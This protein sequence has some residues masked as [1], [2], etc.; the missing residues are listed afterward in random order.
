MNSDPALSEKS[1]VQRAAAIAARLMAIKL[2]SMLDDTGRFTYAYNLDPDVTVASDYNWLRHFGAIYSLTQA[3]E[4][5][6]EGPRYER[7]APA[8]SFAKI[9]TFGQVEGLGEKR[10]GVW[11]RPEF[12]TYLENST[13]KTGG[14]GLA[15]LVFARAAKLG[16]AAVELTDLNRLQAYLLE[17][18][19]EDGSFH[20]FFVEGEGFLAGKASLYY[21]GEAALGLIAHHKLTGS[22]TS[23]EAA[24]DALLYLEL[25]RRTDFTLPPDHWAL[26]ASAE[27][28]PYV[29]GEAQMRI[30]DHARRIS[31]DIMQS[32]V[33]HTKTLL[34]GA[35]TND[36]RTTP[37]AARLEGLSAAATMFHPESEF[38][39]DL[40]RAVE[41]GVAFLARATFLDGP[42]AGAVPGAI[43]RR[44]GTSP[45]DLD[46]NR[47]AT[48][49]RIDYIQHALSACL[50]YRR[51]IL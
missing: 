23:L 41:L 28:L 29:H 40:M 4:M 18:Q 9:Q 3:Y 11:C 21:P 37:T 33:R 48:E 39:S 10:L 36:G 46:F 27:I 44:P 5:K 19:K 16:L 35:F 24:Q 13:I 6:I 50:G 51:Y 22:K 14:V 20:S 15:L 31:Q 17:A 25:C 47:G 8:L 45:E 34:D 32:Q 38:R 43:G 49:V 1:V 12:E 30:V 2:E 7:L 26:I 42:N